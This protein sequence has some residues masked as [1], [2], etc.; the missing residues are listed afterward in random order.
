MIS[1]PPI[2]GVPPFDW[3]AS[4]PSARIRLPIPIARRS[5]M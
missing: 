5:R 4:G 3:W 1:R 2:V